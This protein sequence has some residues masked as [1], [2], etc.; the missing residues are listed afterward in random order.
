MASDYDDERG[1]SRTGRI[2]EEAK[3]RMFAARSTY[4]AARKR[5]QVT[6]QVRAELADALEDYYDALWEYADKNQQI[7]QAWDDSGIGVIEEL[8]TQTVEV[9][10]GSPGRGGNAGGAVESAMMQVDPE[11]LVALSKEL[12]Y[13]AN[14][15]GFG[16]EVNNGRTFGRIGSAELWGETGDDEQ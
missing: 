13:F 7:K 16:K 11:R 14:R 2:V 4:R 8:S 10:R 5:N 15:L 9:A 1:G 12:D 3:V 6:R